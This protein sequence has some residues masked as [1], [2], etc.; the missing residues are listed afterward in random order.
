MPCLCTNPDFHKLVGDTLLPAAGAIAALYEEMGGVVTR[1]GK[2]HMEIY[3]HAHALCRYPDKTKIVSI[4]DSLDHDIRGAETFGIDSV[5]ARTGVQAHASEAALL[6][7]MEEAQLA[8]RCLLSYFQ[9]D[10]YARR[11]SMDRTH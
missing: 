1:I 10:D 2:P 4:G 5:L 7:Q 3:H 11:I 6:V 9:W 8:P